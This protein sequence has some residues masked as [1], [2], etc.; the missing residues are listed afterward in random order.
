MHKECEVTYTIPLTAPIETSHHHI[1][2]VDFKDCIAYYLPF[3][4]HQEEFL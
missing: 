2:K 3:E 4:T 1:Q